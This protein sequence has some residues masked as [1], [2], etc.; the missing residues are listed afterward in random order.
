MEPYK[1]D[2]PDSIAVPGGATRRLK[3]GIKVQAGC[4][5][6]GF[7]RASKALTMKVLTNGVQLSS[8]ATEYLGG[9]S[10]SVDA[11][12]NEGGGTPVNLLLACNEIAI[13][14]TNSGTPTTDDTTALIS[15]WV[16]PAEGGGVVSLEADDLPAGI[17]AINIGTGD[18]D[19]ETFGYLA[20]LSGPIEEQFAPAEHSHDS[21]E[22]AAGSGADDAGGDITISGGVSTGDAAGGSIVF[23]TAPP[24]SAG[25]TANALEVRLQIDQDGV[26]WL[27]LVTTAP[28]AGKADTIGLY[29]DGGALKGIL[30]DDSTGT[31]D[32]TDDNP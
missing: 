14:F 11:S 32:F 3:A 29:N 17:D 4:R 25:E 6:R 5:L 30:P 18:V 23:Q 8:G 24:G 10:I 28:V 15:L 31:F 26:L 9:R 2:A 21:L 16:V 12:S 7:V 22:G 20:G 13:E 19:N 1:I 27:P